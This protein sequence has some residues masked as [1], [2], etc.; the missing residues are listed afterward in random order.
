M[1]MMVR[2]LLVQLLGLAAIAVY[3][4]FRQSFA[5]LV[6]AR[7]ALVALLPGSLFGGR[8]IE[9]LIRPG[10]L[11]REATQ[12]TSIAAAVGINAVTWVIVISV[13]SAR[14]R[15]AANIGAA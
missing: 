11:S 3:F 15:K 6:A 13:L 10:E 1:K 12:L 8:L 14:S 9:W 2:F 4:G 5:G 7:V